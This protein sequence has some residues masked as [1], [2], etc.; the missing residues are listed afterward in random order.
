MKILLIVLLQIICVQLSAQ[1]SSYP[2]NVFIITTD[3]LR[4][5]EVFGG[6][7]KDII[8]DTEFVKDTA[9]TKEMYW[10][11]SPEE[12]RKKLMPFFW[13]T[14]AGKGQLHGNRQ[15]KNKVNV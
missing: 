15:Y 4:W 2:K 14:I 7:D 12:R 13:S 5:Q 9:L 8:S 1:Q 11:E 3:G 10:A 6:A